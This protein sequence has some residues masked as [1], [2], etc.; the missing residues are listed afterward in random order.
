MGDWTLVA[1]IVF[2][3]VQLGIGAFVAR[4]VHGEADYLIAGRSLG[5]FAAG[6]SL[7]ATWFAAESL[8]GASAAIRDEG[9]SGGR[10][11]PMGY[12]LALLLMG[13]LLAARLRRTGARTLPEVL[14]E[15]FGVRVERLSAVLMIP[16]TS[17][18]AAA[19]IRGFGLVLATFSPLEIQSGILVATF[20]VIV[21]TTLGGLL[22]DV[23][24]DV[25]Q[26]GIVLVGVLAMLVA[27]C[28]HLGG[29]SEAF[30]RIEPAQLRLTVAGESLAGR[31]DTWLVPIIGALVVQESVSRVLACRTPRIARRAAL[32]GGGLYA[33]FGL[34]PVLIGLLGAHAGIEAEGEA[35]VP[36]LATT[37]LPGFL[38]V[39]FIGALVAAILSTV[40]SS[41]LAVGAVVSSNLGP[42]FAPNLDDRGRLRL[43]RIATVAT[44]L[45]ACAIAFTTDSIYEIV[46][47]AD[48]LGTAGL[49]VV[50]VAAMRS[51]Y[52]GPIAA[53]S[54]LTGAFATSFVL[55]NF[56]EFEAP[57]L[58]SFGVALTLFLVI[59]AFER[60]RAAQQP[61][62]EVRE[63]ERA[64]R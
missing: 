45:V 41:L 12:A 64:G 28:M 11:D 30:G 31:I 27:L 6:F 36:V 35:F 21:Y 55:G 20:V 44:G 50:C 1:I 15:R 16:T 3:L 38:S 4:R 51:S 61:K 39:I 7:F 19:Q 9:L 54:T 25:L 53:A 29:F 47:L 43:A 34:A 60:P 2:V 63:L 22:G 23:Y 49:A 40:D 62:R 46:L 57:F 8:M 52:G 26:G 59:G 17:L 37:V 58:A 10:A 5:T 33:V 32:L 14:R 48:G 56:T 13:V 24:T 18:Y 42:A